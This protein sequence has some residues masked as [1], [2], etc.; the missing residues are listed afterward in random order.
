MADKFDSLVAEVAANTSVT[1]SAI[2]LI[3]GFIAR[4]DEAKDDPEQIAALVT[5]L[6]SN[7]EGLA[8]AITR[9]TPSEGD[10]DTEG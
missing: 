9:G 5:E 6:R 8:D 1:Q 3:D 10:G 4:F 2:A 7:R